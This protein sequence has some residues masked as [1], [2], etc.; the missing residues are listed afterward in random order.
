MEKVIILL[1]WPGPA[2][3]AQEL[4]NREN[5]ELLDEVFSLTVW[6]KK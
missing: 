6:E 5:I 3:L 4:R 2:Q 1:G